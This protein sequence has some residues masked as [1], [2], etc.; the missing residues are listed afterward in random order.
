MGSVYEDMAA[1]NAVERGFLVVFGGFLCSIFAI[2]PG[3][4]VI[5]GAPPLRIVIGFLFG[6]I[7]LVVIL[8]IGNRS[9]NRITE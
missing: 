3:L 2:Y 7:I 6:A 9:V 4:Y 5:P 1:D 8:S